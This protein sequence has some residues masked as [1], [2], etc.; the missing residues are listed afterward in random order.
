VGNWSA[1]QDPDA[2]HH[3]AAT[4]NDGIVTLYFDGRQVAQG[5][6]SGKG[7]LVSRLG[8]LRFGE[9]YPPTSLNNEPFLGTVDN[10]VVL[11]QALSP[12]QIRS[13]SQKGP[14]ALPASAHDDD[15]LYTMELTDGA[16]V[17][18]Q[19]DPDGPHA[20]QLPASPANAD[21]KLL[22]NF[23][24]SAA[25]SIRC[26]IQDQQGRPLSGYSLED[27]D[28][29]YGDE[30]ARAVSWQGRTELKP[31]AGQPVRLRFVLKDADLYSLQF[32]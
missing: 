25:G 11:R 2:V 24:T 28:V 16:R 3:L 31:L 15:L 6:E 23:S 13:L 10:L 5:G 17:Q 14:Q 30:I 8:N 12:E 21:V 20:L 27:S 18:N 7:N 32:Q 4:W 22:I 26:E 9:D 1:E 19:F 29:L